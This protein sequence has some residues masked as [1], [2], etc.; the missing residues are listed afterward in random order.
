MSVLVRHLIRF[1]SG[2]SQVGRSPCND[3]AFGWHV[4]S[5]R[6]GILFICDLSPRT[7][8]NNGRR[9]RP[10]HRKSCADENCAGITGRRQTNGPRRGRNFHFRLGK[11]SSS[12]GGGLF[13]FFGW[14]TMSSE[15]NIISESSPGLR[16]EIKAPCRSVPFRDAANPKRRHWSV[17]LPRRFID[18]KHQSPCAIV[19]R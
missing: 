18:T 9:L 14:W 15:M 3:S 8:N 12:F 19:S 10:Q 6:I 1:S 16:A 17:V 2:Q 11:S 4:A 13:L 5:P 7:T